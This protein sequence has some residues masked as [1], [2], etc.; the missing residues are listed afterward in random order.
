LY[1]CY[2]RGK[3]LGHIIWRFKSDD[4]CYVR[5]IKD[6]WRYDSS[7]EIA[8]LALREFQDTIVALATPQGVGG[9]GVIR[10]SGPQSISLV[11]SV[12]KG[13]NLSTQVGNTIHFGRIVREEEIIDEV[14]VSFDKLTA[15]LISLVAGNPSS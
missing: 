3:L 1:Y 15:S 9:V 2:N 5:K 10:L 8:K 7:D 4:G 14:L 6:F 12:F 11:N 13:K